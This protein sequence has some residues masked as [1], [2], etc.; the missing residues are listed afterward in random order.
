MID[1]DYCG[2]EDEVKIQMYNFTDQTVDIE[3]GAKIAGALCASGP[4]RI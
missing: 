4:F 3:R 2:P 1:Q